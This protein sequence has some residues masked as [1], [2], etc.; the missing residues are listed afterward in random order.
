MGLAEDEQAQKLLGAA[1]ANVECAGAKVK[2]TEASRL[3][4][5]AER[6]RAESQYERR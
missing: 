3:R 5:N 1:E 2:E 6:R 4:V